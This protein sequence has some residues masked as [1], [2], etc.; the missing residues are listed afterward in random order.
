MNA[1]EN[2]LTPSPQELDE[3]VQTVMARIQ[4]TMVQR[5]LDD[6][7]EYPTYSAARRFPYQRARAVCNLIFRV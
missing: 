3:D 5:A 7:V 1:Q 4:Q 2:E 6:E